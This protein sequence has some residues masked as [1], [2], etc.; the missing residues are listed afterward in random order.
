MGDLRVFLDSCV[1]ES[2]IQRQDIQDEITRQMEHDGNGNSRQYL[3]DSKY[4]WYGSSPSLQDL[5][6]VSRSLQVIDVTLREK[7]EDTLCVA[8]QHYNEESN[9]SNSLSS[10]KEIICNL[11]PL[12]SS[13]HRMKLCEMIVSKRSNCLAEDEASSKEKEI[14]V[15]STKISNDE[16]YDVKSRIHND[17]NLKN[18]LHRLEREK[19]G[20]DPSKSCW[21]LSVVRKG[22]YVDVLDT[23]G[24]WWVGEVVDIFDEKSENGTQNEMRFEIRYRGFNPRWNEEVAAHGGRICRLGTHTGEVTRDG[25]S[26]LD[27]ETEVEGYRILF[28]NVNNVPQRSGIVEKIAWS[29]GWIRPESDKTQSRYRGWQKVEKQPM[30]TPAKSCSHAVRSAKLQW[31]IRWDGTNEDDPASW[32]DAQRVNPERPRDEV[33]CFVLDP[34]D[35]LKKLREGL[36]SFSSGVDLVGCRL[37][38]FATDGIVSDSSNMAR[39]EESSILA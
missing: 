18:F 21:D 35:D 26:V 25:L 13:R 36:S 17:P 15:A 6:Y 4:T 8:L 34:K 5:E 12:A 14:H 2:N 39:W 27:P 30:W 19:G 20:Q 33:F 16:K 9:T 37:L 23:Y 22:D 32:V 11:L 7:I 3:H 10:V 31:L 38:R 29:D 1:R 28:L 24:W